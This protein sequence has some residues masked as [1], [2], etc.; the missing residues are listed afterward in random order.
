[1]PDGTRRAAT[2][3]ASAALERLVRPRS[4]AVVGASDEPAS[5]G[6]APLVLLERFGYEG[7]VHL[8]SRSRREVRGRACVAS[9]EELPF[10]V[11]AAILAIP[12]AGVAD[13]VEQAGRRGVG[14]VV[15]FSSGYGELDAAGAAAERALAASAARHG[16]ALAGPNCLGLVNFADGVPLTF[17]DVAPNRRAGGPGVAIVAQSGAMSL[18]LTYA[19]MAQDTSV[20]YAISTGNEAVLGVEDHLRLVI[21][22]ERTRAVVMLVEQIRRPAEF[23]ALARE[24]REREITVC[25]LHTGRGE[26]AK[27]ASLTHTGAI[28]GDQD[29][30]RS[31]LGREGVLF[32][33]SLDGLV[34]TAGVIARRGLPHADGVAFMTDSGAAKTFAIDVCE[35]E[36][37]VLPELGGATLAKLAGELPAFATASNPVDITAMG[38]NDPS[39]YARVASVLLE[40]DDVGTLV[41]SAMP[42]SELQGTEQVEALLP[43][44]AAARKPVVYTIM[45]GDCPIPERNRLLVLDASVPLFRSPERALRAARDLASAARAARAAESRARAA[46]RA[47]HVPPLG[48]GGPGTAAGTV[49]GELEAKAMLAAAGIESPPSRLVTSPAGAR[50]AARELGCPVVVKISS[51]DITH[52]SD[53]GGVAFVHAPEDAADAYSAVLAAVSASRPDARVDGVLIERVVSDGVEMLLGARRDP[54]W[55]PYLVVGLGGVWTEIVGDATVVAADA[56]RDEIADAISG[57]RG[58]AVLRGAR[59]SRPRDLHAL[60][61]AAE[62][63]A[64][65]VRCSPRVAEIEINPLL[66]RSEGDGVVALDAVVAT[67]AP[68]A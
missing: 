13:A 38:L 60:V 24:A 47:L 45:G 55:G 19:A 1:M 30:L 12:K 33:N 56:D 35:A 46:P 61:G 11:D 7:D 25:V 22:D 16:I 31:V 17:G 29:V 26:R 41:V 65:L 28:A 20:T 14:G 54:A 51:P 44:L 50:D 53:A 43:T 58:A 32:V 57:L 48:T 37:A 3:A 5:I 67:G 62:L 27:A 59:G 39:L 9:I 63:V 36:G 49:F 18:A 15:V 42:G 52:K 2:G 6:G 23:L 21:A 68:P 8:V 34:D 4:V 10:G 40:D 66:V 64:A